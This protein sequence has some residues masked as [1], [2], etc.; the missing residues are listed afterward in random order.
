ME[1]RV[2]NVCSL[3]KPLS[4]EFFRKTSYLRKDGSQGI[5]FM[6]KCLICHNE[7]QRE[8]HALDEKDNGYNTC[9][10]C[11]KRDLSS[12]FTT[13][14]MCNFCFK[15]KKSAQDKE[16]RETHKEEK[17]ATDKAYRENNKDKISEQAAERYASNKNVVCEKASIYYKNKMATDPDFVEK[18]RIRAIE[19]AKRP[20]SKA[21]RNEQRQDRRKQTHRELT[22]HRTGRRRCRHT[23]ET[24]RW[25][26]RLSALN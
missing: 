20:K 26:I 12:E 10:H 6:K 14:F 22:N 13:A 7:W 23:E 24:K 16:Y 17:A 21:R 5:S 19:K 1:T 2:C 3:E 11:G 15:N 18:E 8:N 4:E 9:K 25:T